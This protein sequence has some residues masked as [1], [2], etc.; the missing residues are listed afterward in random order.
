MNLMFTETEQF[1][2]RAHALFPAETPRW[3]D[4][5]LHEG[6]TPYER[7]AACVAGAPAHVVDL[8]CGDGVLA[9][10]LFERFPR[11]LTVTAVDISDVELDRARQRLKGKPV[12]FQL[13]RAQRLSLP[14]ASVDA[15][16]CHMGLMLMTPLEA[17]LREQARVLKPGGVF[18]AVVGR[19]W[20]PGPVQDLFR[21]AFRQ[22][23]GEYGGTPI[24]SLGDERTRTREGLQAAF[25][26]AGAFGTKPEFDEWEMTLSLGPDELADFMMGAYDTVVL[27]EKGREWMRGRLAKGLGSL[28][29]S[30]GRIAYGMGLRQLRARR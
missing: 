27:S 6:G 18:A 20:K 10:K 5:P 17:V 13:E 28:A 21:E 7:L 11:G 25:A 14:T 23:L 1:L 29:G 15:V 16:L 24:G 26:A 9:E 12:T 30:D 22:A 8:A 4:R 2:R 19:G 3:F